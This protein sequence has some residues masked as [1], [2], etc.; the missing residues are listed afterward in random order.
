MEISDDLILEVDRHR[1]LLLS[2]VGAVSCCDRSLIPD[3]I[4]VIVRYRASA[5]SFNKL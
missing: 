2:Q 5:A 3:A 4:V 1:R